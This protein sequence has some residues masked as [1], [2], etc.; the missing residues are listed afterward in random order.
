MVGH[1]PTDWGNYCRKECEEA[2]KIGV[3]EIGGL[4]SNGL[5]IIVEIVESLFFH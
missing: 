5:P 4:D 1:T 2:N 3:L